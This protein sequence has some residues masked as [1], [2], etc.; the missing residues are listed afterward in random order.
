[1]KVSL[2]N[3]IMFVTIF[4]LIAMIGCLEKKSIQKID[5]LESDS[6]NIIETIIEELD[7]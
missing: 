3:Y 4:Y 2:I 5:I 1:M 6:I 7:E